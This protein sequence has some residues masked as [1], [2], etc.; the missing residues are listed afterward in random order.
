[1]GPQGEWS[2]QWYSTAEK[3]VILTKKITKIRQ[4]MSKL[5]GFKISQILSEILPNFKG[6]QFVGV[7]IM[8]KKKGLNKIFGKCFW[9]NFLIFHSLYPY[10][11]HLH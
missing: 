7:K 1:M 5:W 9:G 2:Y 6:P 10:K 11:F 8:G 4:K 3:M